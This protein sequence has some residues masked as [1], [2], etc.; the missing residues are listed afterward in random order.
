MAVAIAAAV[1]PKRGGEDH[2]ASGLESDGLPP[3]SGLP[4]VD[5]SRPVRAPRLSAIGRSGAGA[6]RSSGNEERIRERAAALAQDLEL[7]GDDQSV[8]LEVLLQEQV[9]REAAFRDLRS[10]SADGQARVRALVR[11]ELDE[12]RAWKTA[13]LRREF[14]SELA[15]AIM[16]R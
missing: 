4:V 5:P 14:G 1:A 3:A 15:G 16:R 8:L 10:A 7:S 9:R 2:A 13:E 11:V 6:T 12:I